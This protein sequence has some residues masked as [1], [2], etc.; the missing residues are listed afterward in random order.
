M[1]VECTPLEKVYYNP[2]NG[3]TVASYETDEEIPIEACIQ[4]GYGKNMFRAVGIEL[5]RAHGL[6]V[7]LEGK[8]KQSDYGY[9]LDVKSFHIKTPTSKEGIIQYLSSGLIK[10]IGPVTAERIVNRFGQDTF[11]VFEHE[12]DRLL[13]V[14][15]ITEARLEVILDAYYKSN[16]IKE[17]MVYLSPMG[18]TPRMVTKIQEHFGDAAVSIVKENPYRLCEVKGFG[19]KTVDPIAVKSHSFSPDDP[20]RIKAA[21]HYVL[22][23]AEGEGHLFL[24]SKEIVERTSLLLN[25]R[26]RFGIV[27]QQAIKDAGN[28][29]VGKDRTLIAMTGKAVYEKQHYYAEEDAARDL[30]R[31]LMGNTRQIKVERYLEKVQKREGIAL[32][33]SQKDAVRM[34]FNHGVSIITGGPGCG[35]TTVVRIILG[36]QEEIN[37]DAMILLCAPTGKARRKMYESTGYPALTIQKALGKTGTDGEDAWNGLQMLPDDLIV[38]DEFSMVDMQLASQLFSCIKQGTR[39]IMVGD[40]DQIPSVGPGNV[41]KELIECGIIPTTILDTCFR[42]EK[43]STIGINAKQI[44]HGEVRLKLDDTFCVYPAGNDEQAAEMILKIYQKEWEALGRDSDAIQVLSPL[45]KDT[46]VGANALNEAL[47]DIVNPESRMKRQIKNGANQYRLNDKVMQTKNNDEVSNGDIGTVTRI[48][49]EAGK[50]KM[51]VDFGD[52]RLMVYE[53]DEIWPLVH[54][55]AMSVHKSQGSEYPVVILPMLPC[56]RKMLKR[57][58]FYTAVTRAKAKVIIVGSWSAIYQAIR[59]NDTDKR[60]TMLGARIR[61]YYE[62]RLENLR[63]IA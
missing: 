32:S 6:M 34:A 22:E 39:L 51:E 33:E 9:Q 47:R 1:M 59:S 8:W 5:P 15:G 45:K 55:Y 27:D 54:A 37:R 44:N 18:A 24:P 46:K 3:Y 30:V 58:I 21:I 57:N 35:K 29:M 52:D 23:E 2:D 42:Q 13:N 31:I 53:S 56:F 28:A 60:N 19:F 14:P 7:E 61:Y 17:L 26:Q 50:D 12:P 10:G 16:I 11:Y 48:F 25:H 38:A 41:F 43:G 4:E 49:R 36:V 62:R 63:K 20:F 40:K